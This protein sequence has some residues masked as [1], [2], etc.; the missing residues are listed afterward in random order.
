MKRCPECRRDYYDETLL[1]CLDDGAQLLDGPAS[2]NEPAT[3]VLPGDREGSRR[4]SGEELPT[5]L[6]GDKQADRAPLDVSPF[7]RRIYIR[8][9]LVTLIIVAAFLAFRFVPF[10]GTK[11]I[12]SIAVMP[13]VNES[14]NAELEYLSDGMT[15]TLI[16]S[17]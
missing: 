9:V 14:G 6:Y 8:A 7:R 11:Q 2:E 1:Y 13:F 5:K 17:L 10:T 12:D 16:G 15:E 4:E 3:A